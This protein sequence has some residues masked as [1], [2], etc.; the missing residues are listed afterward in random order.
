[1]NYY[2]GIDVSLKESSVCIVDLTGKVVRDVK[3]VS[4]PEALTVF[5]ILTSWDCLSAASGSRQGLLQTRRKQLSQGHRRLKR[6]NEKSQHPTRRL[7]R[8]MELYDRSF[9]PYAKRLFPD[10]H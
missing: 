5:V 3:V 8:R 6:R 9:R 4:E 1:M 10:G 7:P 2:A